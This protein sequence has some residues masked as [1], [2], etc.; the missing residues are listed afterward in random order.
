ME[1]FNAYAPI[2]NVLGLLAIG[3]GMIWIQWRSGT[4]KMS[5]DIIKTYET[6]IKQL[7][8]LGKEARGEAANMQNKIGELNGRLQEKDERIKILEQTLQGRNPEM[9]VFIKEMS[10]FFKLYKDHMTQQGSILK[11]LQDFV[12]AKR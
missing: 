6:R 1:W 7:E 8:E 11:L 5:G 3:S 4:T 10:E 9:T 2:L 12:G